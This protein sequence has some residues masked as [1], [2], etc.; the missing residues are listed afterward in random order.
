MATQMSPDSS[1]HASPKERSSGVEQNKQHSA[2]VEI[3][4]V[5]V[6]KGAPISG[7]SQK[8]RV[9]KPSKETPDV[10]G[11]I[12]PWDVANAAESMSK[13]VTMPIHFKFLFLLMLCKGICYPNFQGNR[14][15]MP[16]TP[17][18]PQVCRNYLDK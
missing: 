18:S 12:S 8:S 3:R 10:T 15:S 9:R 2:K 1:A 7:H 11:S 17:T 4:D 6:D 16:L 13:Y 14:Y 5:Q